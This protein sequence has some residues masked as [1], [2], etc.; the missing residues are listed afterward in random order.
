MYVL[1]DTHTATCEVFVCL[2]VYTHLCV[3]VG[4]SVC[5]CVRV[6]LSLHMRLNANHH[7][8][9]NVERHQ[10]TSEICSILIRQGGRNAQICSIVMCV[11]MSLRVPV[12]VC[13]LVYVSP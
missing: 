13:V 5:I 11:C 3:R 6:S 7:G 8:Q 1:L 4:V 12:Y 9:P 2:C 10:D